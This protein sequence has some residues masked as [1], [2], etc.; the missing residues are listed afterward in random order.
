ML[1]REILNEVGPPHAQWGRGDDERAKTL[2]SLIKYNNGVWKSAKQRDFLTSDKGILGGDFED[3]R[4]YGHQRRDYPF[5]KS[6]FGVD[7]K[8]PQY[9]I[10]VSG[11]MN[12]AD[13]G[14]KGL[15]HFGNVFVMDDAGVVAKYKLAYTYG[16]GNLKGAASLDTKRIKL[17]WERSG[18]VDTKELDKA[19]KAMA[20]EKKQREDDRKKENDKSDYIGSPG[21]WIKDL[22]V[23]IEKVVD[24]GPG[25]FGNRWM[26][27]MKDNNSNVLNY[28]G[29]PKAETRDEK[30]FVLRAKV[31][32]HYV[33]KNGVKVTV[34]G[35]PKF[36]EQANEA[37]K[38]VFVSAPAKDYG[39]SDFTKKVLDVVDKIS[40]KSNSGIT[41]DDQQALKASLIH[42]FKKHGETLEVALSTVKKIIDKRMS[43]QRAGDHMKSYDA[44]R[45]SL[46]H[47]MGK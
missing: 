33:N 40:K 44:I 2:N 36:T 19:S 25:E 13:Y 27:I 3:S 26:T 32:K 17:E 39:T 18:K 10:I 47:A 45:Q 31:K 23:K 20:D 29:Y 30:K 28:F 11:S 35:Y 5:L 9:A 46:L 34:V 12:F 37:S 22:E 4:G 7:I 38:P 14:S 21:E 6:H 41:H 43:M 1:L 15:R 8:K 16:K 24:L 42:N